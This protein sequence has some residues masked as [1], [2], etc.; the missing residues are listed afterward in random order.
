[1]ANQIDTD[2]KVIGENALGF[3]QQHV[4]AIGTTL[5]AVKITDT[6]TIEVHKSTDSGANWTVDTTFSSL[7]NP[8][9]LSLCKSE[10]GDLFLG[11]VHN[12]SYVIVKRKHYSTGTWT[13]VYNTSHTVGADSAGQHALVVYSKTQT[14]LYLLYN[15]GDSNVYNKRSDDYGGTWSTAT[16]TNFGSAGSPEL[17]LYSACTAPNGNMYYLLWSNLIAQ[18]FTKIIN[19]DGSNGSTEGNITNTLANFYGG[20]MAIDS[21]SN[22]W[23]IWYY[24]SG[25]NY[26]L[27]VDKNA[28]ESLSVNYSTTDT[29][30]KGM[31]SIGIDGAN[32]V[33]IFYTKKT[34]GKCYYRMFTNSTSTWGSE[35]ALTSGDGLRPS[36]EQVSLPSS[37]KLNVIYFTN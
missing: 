36:C 27:K 1:M 21:S 29:I 32:N 37:N 3:G 8:V 13:E 28:S 12:T 20:E 25:G 6:N 11:F 33:Y 19:A 14:R 7:T 22:R 30:Y 4:L 23:R 17:R 2:A 15:S 16:K 35:T 31:L 24:I 9:S 5:Y 18:V 10:Q 26:Y 34:D